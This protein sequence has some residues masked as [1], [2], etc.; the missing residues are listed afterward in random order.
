[1][2]WIAAL[3]MAIVSIVPYFLIKSAKERPFGIGPERITGDRV[4]GPKTPITV[5]VLIV[6]MAILFIANSPEIMVL[7]RDAA[8]SVGLLAEEKHQTYRLLTYMFFHDYVPEL[9]F[10]ILMVAIVGTLLTRRLGN[11][12]VAFI[13]F[14]GGIEA[15]IATVIF[16]QL[17]GITEPLVGSGGGLFA[18]LAAYQ[19]IEPKS[20][21]VSHWPIILMVLVLLCEV[22]TNPQ[23]FV[24]A[25]VGAA[26]GF[27]FGYVCY[28]FTRDNVD[29]RLFAS[30]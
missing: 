21:N 3:E 1:M 26:S 17:S 28:F 7:T 19:L 25:A 23:W 22:L 18:L 16:Q 6:L 11:A 12:E 13:F 15:G 24:C 29:I 14:F 20:R 2:F 5:V 10:S 27:W 8:E 9:F 4:L 30:K